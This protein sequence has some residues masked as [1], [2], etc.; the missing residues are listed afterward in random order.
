MHENAAMS[1]EIHSDLTI[2]MSGY[3]TVDTILPL[4]AEIERC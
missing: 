4:I 3:K 1:K 2:G